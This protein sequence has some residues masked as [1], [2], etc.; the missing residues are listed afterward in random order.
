MK[1]YFVL[2]YDHNGEIMPMTFDGFSELNL[3]IEYLST[4]QNS[5]NPFICVRLINI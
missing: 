1:H 2:G 3:A 4:I 5:F